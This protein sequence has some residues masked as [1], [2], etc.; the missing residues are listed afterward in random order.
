[1]EGPY[2]VTI[3]VVLGQMF[4]FWCF[5]KLSDLPKPATPSLKHTLKNQPCQCLAS[6]RY[7]LASPRHARKRTAAVARNHHEI[8]TPRGSKRH[9][10]TSAARCFQ[11]PLS[12]P[13]AYPLHFFRLK[14]HFAACRWLYQS[15]WCIE[16]CFLCLLL[17][18]VQASA[19]SPPSFISS[20]NLSLSSMN[21]SSPCDEAAASGTTP[22]NRPPGAL[23]IFRPEKSSLKVLGHINLQL[24][25]HRQTDDLRLHPTVVWTFY[26]ETFGRKVCKSPEGLEE[27]WW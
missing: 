20:S 23:G 25:T 24:A 10:P 5:F 17:L 13:F 7:L 6:H 4:A 9:L 21:W 3:G 2:P 12:V 15:V 16:W 27:S 14:L 8:Y 18:R 19:G 26:I 22:N 11:P 1:M